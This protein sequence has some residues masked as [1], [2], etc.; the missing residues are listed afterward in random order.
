MSRAKL[1]GFFSTSSGVGVPSGDQLSYAATFSQTGHDDSIAEA[2]DYKVGED[3]DSA[4]FEYSVKEQYLI[5]G[6]RVL[7][8][9]LK[10]L[11]TDKGH[12]LTLVEKSGIFIDT[13][14]TMADK[15]ETM[16]PAPSTEEEQGEEPV[17]KKP[18]PTPEVP[19]TGLPNPVIPFPNP[20]DNGS[21]PPLPP[22]H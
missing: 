2:F 16:E 3:L 13:G 9:T 19:K 22:A 20:S 12:K 18:T 14:S 10:I 8:G 1:Q 15:I 7:K 11:F 5:T 4:I 17:E 21:L 6:P